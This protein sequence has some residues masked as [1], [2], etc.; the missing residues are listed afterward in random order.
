VGP[1]EDAPRF[2]VPAGSSTSSSG[3]GA[4][5]YGKLSAAHV[6]IRRQLRERKRFDS[7]DYAMEKQSGEAA[8][9]PD[10]DPPADEDEGGS[11]GALRGGHVVM[12]V[13]AARHERTSAPDALPAFLTH[14]DSAP[15][16]SHQV[17]HIKLSEGGSRPTMSQDSRLAARSVILQRKLAERKRFDSADYYK[18]RSTSS[19]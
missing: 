9:S 4:S 10:A 11:A 18:A 19:G 8:A 13:P 15:S 2:F 12:S 17:K 14:E 6:L 1:V 5:K 16:I 3:G 7:A